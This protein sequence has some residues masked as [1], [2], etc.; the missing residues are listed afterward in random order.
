MHD[1]GYLFQGKVGMA[2]SDFYLRNE[3]AVNPFLCCY[4]ADLMNDSAEVSLAEAEAVGIEADVV[5][6]N[7][8]TIYKLDETVKD[9]LAAV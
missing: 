4:A 1:I 5:F 8:V 7:C 6:L 2:Q 9:L 3:R